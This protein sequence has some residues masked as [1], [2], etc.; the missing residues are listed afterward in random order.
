MTARIGLFPKL[1][2]QAAPVRSLLY[3]FDLTTDPMRAV[4]LSRSALMD[5]ALAKSGASV[6]DDLAVTKLR[7]G[8]S[9]GTRLHHL[10][11]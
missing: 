2:V 6:R 11:S 1:T 8:D 4:G 10:T 5:L 9:L 7:I 3:I